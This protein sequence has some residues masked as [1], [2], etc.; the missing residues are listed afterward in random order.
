M[1]TETPPTAS[2]SA[3]AE[4]I[5]IERRGSAAVITLDRP[6]ALNALS[7]GMRAKLIQAVSGFGRDPLLY[8][9]VLKSAA[10]RAFS[11]GGDVREMTGLAAQNLA[12]ARQGLADE[13]RLCWLME[14]LPKPAVSFIDGRVMG[15]GVG[16]SLYNTHRVAGENYR[17]A[18]PEA[19]IGYFPDCGVAHAFARMPHAFGLYLGLTG[20][21]IGAAD[22]YA[23]GLITHCIPATRYAAIEERLADADPIDPILDGAHVEPEPSPLMA[24]A[25]RIE[26]VFGA[27]SLTEIVRRLEAEP[28]SRGAAEQDAEF[29]AN[30]LALLRQSSPTALAVT[31]RMIRQARD[32]DIREAL[33]QDYRLAHRFA[34]L[35]DFRE[36]V[37]AYLIEKDGKPNWDPARIEDVPSALIDAFFAP[38]GA[39]EL[40][41]PTR[42]EMQTRRA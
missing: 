15:T 25:E 18:M 23:L 13:L 38:L 1:A 41:L 35:A 33:V 20:R 12:A 40:A 27:P 24:E 16:I 14:C 2:P 5:R 37:R 9:V 11:V 32:M 42:S 17:F 10:P 34:A 19:Q 26:R 7:I 4:H 3:D 29:R 39:A 21:E 8:A 22:A 36:G 28:G 6:S 31:D 30:T